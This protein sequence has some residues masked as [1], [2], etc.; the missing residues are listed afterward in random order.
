[1]EAG[2]QEGYGTGELHCSVASIAD[3]HRVR[4][5]GTVMCLCR[6]CDPFDNLSFYAQ[7]LESSSRT[8]RPV[9]HRIS[10]EVESSEARET[11]RRAIGVS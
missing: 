3:W 7:Y 9:Q 11:L 10:S 4:F 1:M 6:D 2:G 5:S 8:Y